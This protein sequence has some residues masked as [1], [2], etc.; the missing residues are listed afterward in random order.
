[1]KRL[2]SY[3]LSLHLVFVLM[4]LSPCSISA[5]GFDDETLH[6]AIS[7]KWGLIQK[8][9]GEAVLTSRLKG[10]TYRF[11]L[12]ARTKPWADKV[13][14]VRDT[15]VAKVTKKGFLPVSYMKIAHEGG[16]YSKDEITYSRSGNLVSGTCVRTRV[17]KGNHSRSTVKLSSSGP[18]FDM[19]SV[20]YYLRTIDFSGLAKGGTH[21]VSVFSGSKSEILTI[22][23]LGEEEISLQGKKKCRAIHIRFKFTT[24]GKKKSSEDIDCWLSTDDRHIPLLL[25]GSLPVGQVR[26]RYIA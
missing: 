15:L 10:D 11:M 3:V 17:K 20:F 4:L 26:C 5:A 23:G 1:M 19:L 18:V 7:Y 24:E 13:F 21:R 12:T 25:V 2:F 22:R 16:K 8:D 14:M 9:A 6:Y